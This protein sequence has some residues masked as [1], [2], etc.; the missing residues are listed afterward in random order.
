MKERHD[1]LD[2]IVN[3]IRRFYDKMDFND[4]AS[5]YYKKIE[6]GNKEKI[7]D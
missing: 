5:K 2:D 7:F 4:I 3:E 1:G 6:Q